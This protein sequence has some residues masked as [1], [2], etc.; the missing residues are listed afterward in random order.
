MVEL[1]GVV[2]D[3]GATGI[4][5]GKG[6]E[7]EFTLSPWRPAPPAK[8]IADPPENPLRDADNVQAEPL[9]VRGP[10]VPEQLDGLVAD[11]A[12][13]RTVRV[14]AALSDPAKVG[15]TGEGT[16]VWAKLDEV[17]GVEPPDDRL[18]AAAPPE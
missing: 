13:G 14:A 18:E 16:A 17:I 12:P 7:L 8:P 5:T 6:W 15:A 10:V 1:L 9:R 4:S 2:N 11:L 3:A